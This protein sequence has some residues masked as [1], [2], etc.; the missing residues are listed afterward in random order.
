ML[1]QD[2]GKIELFISPSLDLIFD[3]HLKVEGLVKVDKGN[4]TVK[5]LPEGAVNI[6]KD[7]IVVDAKQKKTS[8][9]LPI[10]WMLKYR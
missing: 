8:A 3:E 6:S 1:I 4:I 5:E 7:V 9:D 10:K 2:Y